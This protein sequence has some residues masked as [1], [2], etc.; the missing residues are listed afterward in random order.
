MDY[1][2]PV[3]AFIDE[4]GDTGL[5]LGQGSSPFFVVSLVLFENDEEAEACK[6]AIDDLRKNLGLPSNFEFHFTHNAHPIRE[7]FLSE[8]GR[9]NFS[10]FSLVIDKRES[11]LQKP[12]FQNKESFYGFACNKV[13]LQALP[14]LDNAS[15]VIDKTGN[16]EFRVG[17]KKLL[18]MG[19]EIN[20]SAIKKIKQQESRKVNLLQLADYVAGVSSRLVQGRRGGE[21]YYNLIKHREI[22]TEM[23]P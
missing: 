21:Q 18:M 2:S 17:I 20:Y 7:A 23:Y 8:V 19:S 6:R 1:M 15:I 11:T 9:F 10:Y 5:K 22:R 16:E 4:S 13:I 14:L 3:L 12:M